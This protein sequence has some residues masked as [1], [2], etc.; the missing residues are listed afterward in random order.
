MGKQDI[1]Y[2][3]ISFPT[4]TVSLQNFGLVFALSDFFSLLIGEN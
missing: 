2:V 1:L 4:F 3:L